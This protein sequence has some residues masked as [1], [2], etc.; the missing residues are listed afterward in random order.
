MVAVAGVPR[1]APNGHGQ[2]LTKT[3]LT[4]LLLV[5][6]TGNE[7]EPG[8]TPLGQRPSCTYSRAAEALTRTEFEVQDFDDGRRSSSKFW[9]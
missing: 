2:R 5:F 8:L 3:R 9:I 1:V 6:L 4:V 7:R